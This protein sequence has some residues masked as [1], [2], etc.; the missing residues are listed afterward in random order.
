MN[1]VISIVL[2]AGVSDRC[3]LHRNHKIFDATDGERR[4]NQIVIEGNLSR[5]ERIYNRDVLSAH[6]AEVMALAVTHRG[7]AKSSRGFHRRER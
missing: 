4:S 3:D 1:P 2:V 6:R 5:L 7:S